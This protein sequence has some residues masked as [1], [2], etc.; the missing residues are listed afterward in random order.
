MGAIFESFWIE[1]TK[2]VEGG[3]HFFEPTV[4]LN[5]PKSAKIHICL[6]ES[7]FEAAVKVGFRAQLQSSSCKGQVG[8]LII[9]E[10]S[11]AATCYQIR[12]E[13]IE[14][15]ILDLKLSVRTDSLHYH[16]WWHFLPCIGRQLPKNS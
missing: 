1:T 4:P 3:T 5:P 6:T 13:A 10:I 12:Q 2:Q 9:S 14:L 8:Q 16:I 11:P 7:S 15:Q